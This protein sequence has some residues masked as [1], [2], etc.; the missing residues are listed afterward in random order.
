LKKIFLISY[1]RKNLG[2]DL[3]IKM[4]LE[5]YPMHEF[6]M[7]IK[8]P[9]YLEYFSKYENFH[10]IEGIDSGEELYHS[11]INDYDAYIY[12]GGSIFME[13]KKGYNLSEEALDF[14]KRCKESN[15]P[16]CY[17]SCNY[18]PYQT[19]EYFNLSKKV[20]STCSDICFR[21]RYSYELFQDI[22]NV[23]YA[24]DFVFTYPVI[25][26][27]K[28]KDSIGITVIDLHIREDLKDKENEYIQMLINNIN[29]YIKQGK[30]VYLYSFCKREGDEN[31]IDQVAEKVNDNENLIVIKYNGNIEE[32]L[33]V[34]NKMEYIICARFHAM[35][36]SSLLNQ[37]M[38]IMS[39][40]AKIDHVNEDLGFNLPTIHFED[41]SSE[42]L[43]YLDEFKSVDQE[44]LAQIAEKAKQQEQAIENI[45]K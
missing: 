1:A 34:Y 32:F 31:T 29:E 11:N 35:I 36:L 40:S 20:F 45:L 39:Y 13:G 42:T 23:R 44:E 10:I 14:I 27:E 4:L 38:Y 22:E 24:P 43:I 5:R 41:I 15:I 30:K 21:D 8:K 6:Y 28:I 25:N 3:F 26:E 16:F 9:E 19:E 37:K 18:G 12:V 7:K 33:K 2:D 17:A